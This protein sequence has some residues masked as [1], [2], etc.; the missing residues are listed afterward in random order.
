MYLKSNEAPYQTVA[1]PT[2]RN[3]QY[4]PVSFWQETVTLTPGEPLQRERVCDVAI[5][6][7]GFTGLSVAHELKAAAPD[8]DVVVL[9]RAVVG[10]GA[11]GRNGGFAMPLLGWDLTHAARRL[12][13]VGA[14]LAYR[15]MYDA[16]EHLQETVRQHEIDCDLEATG[17]L[18]LATCPARERHLRAEAALAE[19]LGFEQ[20]WIGKALVQEHIRSDAFTGGLLDPRPVIVNPAK[21]ARGL[22][23]LVERDEVEVYEQTPLVELID[24]DPLVLRTPE[25]RVT[26]RAV[27]MATNGYS[28]AL[29]FMANRVFPVHTYIVLTDPL[30]DDQLAGIGWD[31]HRTSLETSRNFIHYFRL[32][33]DNRILFGGEDANLYYGGRYRDHHPP[34]FERLEARFREYFPTLSDVGI[35]HRWGGVLGVTLDMFPTFGQGG[36]GGSIFHAIGYCGHGVA[37]ANYAGRI[38]APQVLARLGMRPA[39]DDRVPFFYGRRPIALPPEPLRYVGVQAYRGLLRL[40]DWWQGA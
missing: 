23:S 7:G 21:L 32:T 25:G 16:I 24:D 6:G 27:V 1:P 30:S 4:R 18:L 15:L 14:G 11:S 10:H 19:R 17:Y 5:V 12:G 29:G 28:G 38:L 22:K 33:A 35:S 36:R 26:A 13:E 8:L 37:L 31:R 40:G 3:G 2:E 39:S 9:E 20:Q 34:T